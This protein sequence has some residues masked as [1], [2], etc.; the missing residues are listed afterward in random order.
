M[1]L[2]N[3]NFEINQAKLKDVY[4]HLVKCSPYFLPPL[5]SYVNIEN[6]AEKIISLSYR[7]EAWSSGI[8]VG[9]TAIYLSD[10][11]KNNA[12]ITNVSVLPEYQR[13]SIAKVSIKNAIQKAQEI[14][15]KKVSLSV[16]AINLIA[17]TL[18]ESFGFTIKNIK[19]NFVEMEKK[20]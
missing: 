18:Y 1:S 4:E 2:S 8:L 14:G 3:I 10:T 15:F 11:M 13:Y 7:F 9:L 19:D 5:S 12:F 6:Y 16:S 20:I 17:I